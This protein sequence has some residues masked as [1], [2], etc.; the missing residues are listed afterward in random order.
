MQYRV[1]Q[2]VFPK[3]GAVCKESAGGLGEWVLDTG[4]WEGRGTYRL[5]CATRVPERVKLARAKRVMEPVAVYDCD[6][7]LQPGGSSTHWW[8]NQRLGPTVRVAL[9]ESANAYRSG[10]SP[11]STGNLRRP[12]PY[13]RTRTFGSGWWSYALVCFSGPPKGSPVCAQRTRAQPGSPALVFIIMTNCFKFYNRR[14]DEYTGVSN[15]KN[16]LR[17]LTEYIIY[18]GNNP[19]WQ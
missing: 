6:C 1:E 11:R 17:I 10:S 2:N 12:R 19:F 14:P 8:V 9:V 16:A 15:R 4:V 5:M 7:P 13:P 18:T 3:E